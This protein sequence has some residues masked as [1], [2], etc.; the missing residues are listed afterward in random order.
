MRHAAD[1]LSLLLLCKWYVHFMY[2]KLDELAVRSSVGASSDSK[3]H[4]LITIRHRFRERV[5]LASTSMSSFASF[6]TEIEQYS[7]RNLKAGQAKDPSVLAHRLAKT[8]V[9]GR[10]AEPYASLGEKAKGQIGPEIREDGRTILVS[11]QAQAITK[12]R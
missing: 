6:Q 1:L 4:K 9:G 8:N 3:L 7:Q 12:S 5:R 2:T 11:Y 10:S